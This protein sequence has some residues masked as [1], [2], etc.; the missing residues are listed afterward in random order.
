MSLKIKQSVQGFNSFF[1]KLKHCLSEIVQRA[2]ED[3]LDHEVSQWLY[4]DYHQRRSTVNR[5]LRRLFRPKG[6]F[7][8]FTSMQTTVAR[9]LDPKRLT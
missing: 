8:S 2:I 6:A 9:V 7:H 3:Q 5:M 1:S 4:R